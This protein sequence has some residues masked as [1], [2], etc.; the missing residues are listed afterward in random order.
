MIGNVEIGSGRITRY[1][2][3]DKSRIFDRDTCRCIRIGI[4]DRS[5]S[6]IAVACRKADYSCAE[7]HADQELFH[8]NLSKLISLWNC[9]FLAGSIPCANRKRTYI[10]SVNEPPTGFAF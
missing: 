6:V 8:V 1:R 7:C 2:W 3:K 10:A 5:F 4:F 9:R